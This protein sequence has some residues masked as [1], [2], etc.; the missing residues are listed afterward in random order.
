MKLLKFIKRLIRFGLRVIRKGYY[1]CIKRP[2]L[3]LITFIKKV[4]LIGKRVVY[5]RLLYTFGFPDKASQILDPLFLDSSPITQQKIVRWLEGNNILTNIALD[6]ISHNIETYNQ[7]ILQYIEKRKVRSSR[8]PKVAVYTAISGHY[9]TLKP[10][11]DINPDYDYIIFTDLEIEKPGIYQVRPLPYMDADQTRRARY[12]KTHAH[13][14]L[15][16]YDYAIWV[17]AN[18][19]ITG[20]LSKYLAKFIKTGLDVGA[21]QHP[22]RDSV[23]DEAE[24]CLKANKG[25]ARSI[26]EQISFYKL[27]QFDSNNMLE[28]GFLIYNLSSKKVSN[29]LNIWWSHIDKF[30]NRDQLSVGYAQELS[31]ASIHLMLSRPFSARNIAELK[32]VKHGNSQLHKINQINSLLVSDM[33]TPEAHSPQKLEKI[34]VDIIYCVHNALDDVKLC[35]SSVERHLEKNVRLIIVDDGSDK[36]TSEYLQLFTSSHDWVQIIRNGQARGYTVAA[37]QGLRHSDADFR[38]LLNS[39]TVVTAGWTSKLVRTA[40]S[41]NHIGIVGPLSSAAS[42]QSIPE[43]SNKNNQTATNSLP[44]G[45]TPENMNEFCEQSSKNTG[46]S[47][48]LVPLIHGFCFGIKKEVIKQIGYFDEKLFPRGYGEENDYCFRAADAGFGLAVSVDTYIYHA[49]SKSFVSTERIQLMKNGL[50][51]NYE[52]HGTMRVQRAVRTMDTHPTLVKLR[53]DAS[54]FIRKRSKKS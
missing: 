6:S 20:D 23:Y 31:G 44:E 27:K 10:P 36:E 53:E 25:D 21:V 3:R 1:L 35:L 37:S 8:K 50:Q 32:L 52:Q 9:D 42:H 4:R 54:K 26:Q 34:S 2:I 39:D 48:I 16:D 12:V 38:V 7:K 5:A 41:S 18:L 17:D 43:H 28:T 45:V 51:K 19:M 22:L 33:V 46:Q 40:Y 29:F 11:V 13:T 24:E 47:K 49:K 15:E 14:L 30:S